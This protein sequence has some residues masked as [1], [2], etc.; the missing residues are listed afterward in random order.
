MP[1]FLTP[2]A[3]KLKI[4]QSSSFLISFIP[5]TFRNWNSP[6]F[7]NSTT[8]N[9][10]FRSSNNLFYRYLRSHLNLYLNFSPKKKKKKKECHAVYIMDIGEKLVWHII[11]IYIIYSS[12]TLIDLEY[13]KWSLNERIVSS[14]KN[15]C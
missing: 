4:N 8:F 10:A 5:M 1:D 15:L 11:N 9:F 6:L 14:K 13:N 7:I 12:S 3:I 2:F